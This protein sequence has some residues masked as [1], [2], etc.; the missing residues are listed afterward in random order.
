VSLEWGHP[1]ITI[2][3]V[4]LSSLF[5]T[6][7]GFAQTSISGPAASVLFNSGGRAGVGS[8]LS[9][10]LQDTV[11]AQIRPTYWKEG[12]LVGGVIGALGGALLGHGL[13][14]TSEEFQK[15]CTGSLILGGVLGAALLAIPGALIG[16]QFAKNASAEKRAVRHPA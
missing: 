3:F 8:I 10:P 4:L 16:G 2:L 5:V 13:C 14:E 12:A 15:N 6:A 7:A 1:V 9:E 11:Q